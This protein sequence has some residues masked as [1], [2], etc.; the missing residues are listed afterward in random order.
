MAGSDAETDRL[1]LAVPL[2]DEVRN[3]LVTELPPLPGRPVPPRNW[4]FTLRFLG[5]TKAHQRD[6]LTSALRKAPLGAPFSIRFSGLGAFPRPKRAR[7]IWLGVD[8]G[9][10]ELASLAK[11]VESTVRRAGFPPEQ[12]PF[13][14]HLTI[15]R[16]E[17][18]Q[19]VIEVLAGRAPLAVE[20]P[21]REVC[22][23][24]SQLGGGPARYEVLHRF[25]L[26][27]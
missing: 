25:P 5:D 11:N 19:P 14:A 8:E 16:V 1:F 22:L 21:V 20:M 15:S 2:T 18:S 17:P 10:H 23:V 7:I 27:V 6:V 26:A 9:A 3:E 13:K 24:R 12:R 4:H